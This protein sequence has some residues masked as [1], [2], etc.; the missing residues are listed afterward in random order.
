MISKL[1]VLLS[2][3][4]S[5]KLSSSD[6]NKEIY[7]YSIEVLLSLLINIIILTVAAYILKKFVELIVF[8]IFFS[9]LRIFA[10]G[11]HSKTHI[12]CFTVTL[13]IFLISALSSTYF[14]AIGEGILVFGILF[15]VLM[16]FWLAPSE[17]EN[18]PLNKKERKKYKII[19]RVSVIAFS[20]AVIVLYYMRDKIGYIYIT[21]AIAMII[22]SVSLVKVKHM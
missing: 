4:L 1:S 16:I 5:V 12:E 18:K 6:D 2:E 13:I 22:E 9:G 20:L 8:T 17:A 21:A 10:G 7:K 11:Y 14:I 3:E 15:S 19:S